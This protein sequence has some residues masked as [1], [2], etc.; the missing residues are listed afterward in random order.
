MNS[1]L[2]KTVDA[3]SMADL[4]CPRC[5]ADNLHHGETVFFDRKEDAEEVTRITV[6]GADVKVQHGVSNEGNPSLRREGMTI[7]FSCE[8]CIGPIWL[9]FAQHKGSTEIGWHFE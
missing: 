8:Q 4:L 1:K 2:I 3:G 5:G 7:R 9:T 6:D